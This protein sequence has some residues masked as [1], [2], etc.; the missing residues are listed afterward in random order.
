MDLRKILILFLSLSFLIIGCPKDDDEETPAPEPNTENASGTVTSATSG[1][2]E[3]PAGARMVIPVGAVPMQENG[4]PGTMVFSIERNNDIS[5]NVPSEHSRISDVYQ[6]GP[7]GFTFARPVE[8]SIPIPGTDDPGDVALWRRNPTTGDPE[9]FSASYDPATRLVTA[10]TF[11]LS[12][13]FVSGRPVNDDASGCL[14]VT[15]SGNTWLNV[16][17]ETVQLEYTY[18]NDWIPEAGQGVLYAPFGT[19][20]WTHQ[21]NWYL[22][23]GTYTFCLQREST[24]TPGLYYHRITDPITIGDAWHYN[25]PHCAELGSSDFVEADTGRCSCVPNAS[26]SVGTGDIQVTLQWFN[27]SS[28]DLDL[29]VMDPDSEVCYY[30]NNP[31][32][33]GGVLDRDNLCGNYENGRPENIFWTTSPPAGEYVVFV[34]WFYD[35]GNG[36]SSQAINVRTVVRGNTR[37]YSTTIQ[38][39]A[40]IE[41]AR[42][43]LSGSTVNFLLPRADSHLVNVERKPKL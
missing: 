10:Q 8:I 13:W 3:T 21:G 31:S 24:I 27:Q 25:D 30:G 40:N 11:Q 1:E 19:I 34:D 29:W 42:F 41:V 23:Q 22:P 14:R 28:L 37:T 20:G 36:L 12:P 15:N 17:V 5:V 18:Q 26:T 2:I 16:C 38:A 9:F 7:E 32:S 4:D 33:S 35:C 39:D 6:L 43:T